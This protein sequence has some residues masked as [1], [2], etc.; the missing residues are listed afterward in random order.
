VALPDFV[1]WLFDGEQLAV[2]E[3]QGDQPWEQT[4]VSAGG[5]G[6]RADCA[7]RAV[8]GVHAAADCAGVS[9]V[10]CFG[11]AGVFMGARA[12]AS[13]GCGSALEFSAVGVRVFVVGARD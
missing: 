8:F 4:S 11:A 1:Y 9:G 3:R 7:G 10:G 6:G 13:Y 5:C 12:T 2:L